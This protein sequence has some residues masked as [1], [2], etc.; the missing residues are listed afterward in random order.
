MNV[1][2]IILVVSFRDE[3]AILHGVRFADQANLPKRCRTALQYYKYKEKIKD[4]VLYIH[5]LAKVSKNGQLMPGWEYVMSTP[6]QIREL[7]GE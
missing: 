6:R 5:P 1:D 7:V 4:A 3:G 2:W